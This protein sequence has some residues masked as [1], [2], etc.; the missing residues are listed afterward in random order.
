MKAILMLFLAT[1]SF[2][3]AAEG[4]TEQ[5]QPAT[6]QA[7]VDTQQETKPIPE[8]VISKLVTPAPGG[9]IADKKIFINYTDN[10]MLTGLH[11]ASLSRKGYHVVETPEAADIKVE[12]TSEYAIGG[13]LEHLL[14]L[15]SIVGTQQQP[16]GP[17]GA[18]PDM[19]SIIVYAATGDMPNTV[20]NL[21]SWVGH[22]VGI[23]GRTEEVKPA[24]LTECPYADCRL[25]QSIT[26]ACQGGIQWKYV[27]ETMDEDFALNRIFAHIQDGYFN[28][29]F[30]PLNEK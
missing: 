28:D 9:S 14:A 24:K 5:A 11:R 25:R 26:V 27:Y 4:S 21:F 8:V 2:Y 10:R 30:P 29:I 17:R 15:P 13:S 19:G 16:I 12:C 6:E 18:S 1:C 22:K 7:S 20:G 23:F 3:A